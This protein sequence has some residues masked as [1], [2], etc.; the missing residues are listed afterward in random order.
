MRA[1]GLFCL[2]GVAALKGAALSK[3]KAVCSKLY[4][5]TTKLID[6]TEVELATFRQ[7]KTGMIRNLDEV[8][9]RQQEDRMTASSQAE[10]CDMKKQ[11]ATANQAAA[12]STLTKS[13]GDMSAAL[14]VHK[15]EQGACKLKL[16]HVSDSVQRLKT[17][18]DTLRAA[19]ENVN[20]KEALVQLQVLVKTVA[21]PQSTQLA[22][23]SSSSQVIEI[24][25]DLLHKKK[26]EYD[27][28]DA[29]GKNKAHE[30]S[31]FQ[32][33]QTSVQDQA[34][35]RIAA[36]QNNAASAEKCH[37][38]QTKVAAD[39]DRKIADNTKIKHQAEVM[40]NEEVQDKTLQIDELV[41]QKD[42]LSKIIGL[43]DE[44]VGPSAINLASFVQG[45]SFVQ[46]HA[47]SLAP[48][49][50]KLA[51]FLSQRA[52]NLKSSVLAALASKVN[53]GPFDSVKNM[54]KELV[55]K[56][57]Q[58]SLSETSQDGFCKKNQEQNSMKL[59]DTNDKLDK[60]SADHEK[61]KATIDSLSFAIDTAVEE[62]AQQRSELKKS[63]EDRSEQSENNKKQIAEAEE[64]MQG[65][66]EI[67]S[68][69]QETMGGQESDGANTMDAAG[70]LTELMET[71]LTNQQ[72]LLEE[73]KFAETSSQSMFDA[74]KQDITVSISGSETAKEN[75]IKEKKQHEEDLVSNG[76][77]QVT[78]NDQLA[79]LQKVKNVLSKQCNRA[80]SHEETMQKKKEEIQSL[81]D[82]L[83]MLS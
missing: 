65:L 16:D 35:A 77:E 18:I 21:P 63:T 3:A 38:T 30:F 78:T 33:E 43:L 68:I 44:K 59:G 62:I 76:Q 37:G 7:E 67:L 6:D 11:A 10:A 2:G 25:E 79:A 69:I 82:A 58:E 48:D 20:Q 70:R 22:Y 57:Q 45:Q 42:G 4:E 46:L 15:T 13:N 64:A 1:F 26:E 80:M 47:G 81:Q 12:Q 75:N 83:E 55:A 32:Q 53:G 5:E 72:R 27:A 71:L 39:F 40:L 17:A 24:A 66:D 41:K 61:L 73:T 34:Q 19:R 49:S 8:I 28:V 9:D 54:I 52:E 50:Q 60:L 36:A 56:L 74:L 51:A 29:D 31:L 23:D 14:K